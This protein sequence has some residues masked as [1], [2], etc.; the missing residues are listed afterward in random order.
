MCSSRVYNSDGFCICSKCRF[1]HF[2]PTYVMHYVSF[3][4]YHLNQTK[5]SAVMKGKNSHPAL[6]LILGTDVHGSRSSKGISCYCISNCVYICLSETT[7]LALMPCLCPSQKWH[8]TWQ[9]LRC[10]ACWE[11]VEIHVLQINLILGRCCAVFH[12]ES[13]AGMNMSLEA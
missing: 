2:I 9:T 5:N 13:L 12:F 8:E 7:S 11:S 4:D 10:G 1:P 3:S 6:C